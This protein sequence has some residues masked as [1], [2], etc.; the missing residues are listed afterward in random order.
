VSPGAPG[1]GGPTT[2]YELFEALR[3]AG[4]DC[5]VTGAVALAL[6]G[7]PRL[8]PDVDL[9]VG[10]EPG[11][12]E[13]LERVL[14]AWGYAE[15][16]PAERTA[17][18]VPV[19]RYRHPRSAL[20]EIDV[21]LPAAAQFAKLRAGAEVAALV[22]LAIAFV[23]SDDLAALATERGTET[24]R[25]DAAGLRALA[26]IRAGTGCDGAD[27]RRE[28]IRKFSRWSVAARLDWLL[29]AARL[30]RGMSPEA[31]TPTRGL[32][33]RHGWYGRR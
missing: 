16:A 27:T 7:V 4:V 24:G 21:V 25:E 3:D 14:A 20:G 9:A 33:R 29:A 26:E 11:N 18:G 12:V 31:K 15:A 28:Q 22:D 17:G 2:H 19:R 5:L 13:R 32:H 23:G 6:H 1:P 30:A 10:P 8:T